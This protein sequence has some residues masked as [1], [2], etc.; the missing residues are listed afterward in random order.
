MDGD[1]LGLA[2]LPEIWAN[3]LKGIKQF[4]YPLLRWIPLK[5]VQFF[6]DQ[7]TSDATWADVEIQFASPDRAVSGVYCAR[8][9]KYKQVMTAPKSPKKEEA[10]ELK[11]V[12]QYRVSQL[13]KQT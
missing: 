8:V 7:F 3:S 1:R 9:E 12:P 2:Y 6:V 4:L 5:R 10:P 11:P 13:V